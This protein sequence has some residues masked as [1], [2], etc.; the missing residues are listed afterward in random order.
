MPRR[1]STRDRDRRAARES[2]MRTQAERAARRRQIIA[3]AAV[4]VVLLLV[5][6]TVLAAANSS[7]QTATTSTTA[8]ADSSTTVS[9]APTVSV[10]TANGAAAITGPTPCPA[11]DG[12]SPRTTSFTQPPPTCIDPSLTYDATVTTSL[13]TFTFFLNSKLAPRSVNNFIVLARYH[14]YDGTSVVNITSDTDFVAGVVDNGGTPGPGYTLP[15]EYPSSGTAKGSVIVPGTLALAP[16][17]DTDTSVS[18]PFLVSTGEKGPN[19]PDTTTVLGVMLS[20]DPSNLLH[21]IDLLGTQEGGPTKLVTIKSVTV[22]VVPVTS[23]TA[24]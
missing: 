19:L 11:E 22:R 16:T 3:I 7:N 12:S 20:A 24:H 14:Y 2:V 6:A 23:T 9:E 21:Q 4:I 1:T 5:G 13:G 10:P 17:S 8:S 15:A 18:A